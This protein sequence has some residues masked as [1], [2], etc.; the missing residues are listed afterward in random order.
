MRRL[1]TFAERFRM[2]NPLTKCGSEVYQPNQPINLC[3]DTFGPAAAFMR[4]LF[5]YLY[6][7]DGLTLVPHVPP[8]ITELEQ[9]DPVRFGNKRI[10]LS[11]V[12]TGPITAVRVNGRKWKQFDRA[13]VFLPYAK[14][15]NLAQVQIVLGDAKPTGGRASSRA[16]SSLAPLED[17]GSR[18]RSPSQVTDSA[19]GPAA[20]LAALEKREN[21]LRDFERRLAAAGLEA[22]YEARHAR[23][24]ADCVAAAGLRQQLIKD[25]KIKP[26]AEASEAAADRCYAETATKLCNGLEAVLKTYENAGD[27]QRRQAFEAWVKAAR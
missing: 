1:L 27:R 18:G 16:Q 11:T 2:D 10:L 24:A 4:G 26:L 12:G 19:S 3:Y 13:T 6:R 20:E 17:Q 15:P 14:T 7:A 9:C 21:K 25:G 23:L 8:A 5:E 22:S